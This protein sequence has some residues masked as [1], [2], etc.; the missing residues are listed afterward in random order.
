MGAIDGGGAVAPTPDAS[1]D[2]KS[3]Q[4]P[5]ILAR[6]VECRTDKALAREA[7]LAE[8]GLSFCER[9][10]DLCWARQ[11]GVGSAWSG[12]STR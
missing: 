3:P 4:Q 11:A 1:F 12:K 6:R 2:F 9:P 8:G 5:E 10:L 7:G